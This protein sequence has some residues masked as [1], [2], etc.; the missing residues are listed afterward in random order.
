MT[1]SHKVGLLAN[2]TEVSNSNPLPTNLPGHECL[3]NSSSDNLII[4]GVFTGVWED[5]LNYNNIIIGIRSDQDSAVDGLVI[6]WSA[7]GIDVHDTD[8]FTLTANKG[9]VFTFCPARRY[10]RIVYTNGGTATTSFSLQTIL[11]KAGIKPSS[12]RIQDSIVAEDDAELVKSVLTGQDSNGVFQNVNTTPDGDLTI[13]DNSSGLSIAEGNVTGKTFVH[14]FGLAPDFDAADGEVTVWDGSDDGGLNQMTYVWSTGPD[15]D[16]ISSSNSGDTQEIQIQG[17]CGVCGLITQTATLN[18]QNKVTLTTPLLRVFRVKNAGTS[19]LSGNCYVYEDTAISGGVPIDTT[20]VKA[21]INN[22]NN[23]TLMAIYSIPTGSTGYMR[24]WYVATAGASKASN[25]ILRLWA[26]EY[27]ESASAYGA[28]QLKHI[29][30]ISD[31][32]TSAYKHNYVE[33]ER[34]KEKVDIM[35]TVEMT[36]SGA[37]GAAVAAGFDIV[38]VDN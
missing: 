35:M 22:G 7:N 3:D 1:H 19:P 31:T 14:K 28:W 21:L 37:S 24:D 11:K 34:F 27:I 10:F 29:T 4:D 17:L 20:K 26:R 33:P 23:Q 5:T 36:A 16:T 12:H 8:E 15:I 32:G 13:S 18:G 38:L 6:Q 9:K 30:S 2:N 25:Y